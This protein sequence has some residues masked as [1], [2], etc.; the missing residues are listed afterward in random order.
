MNFS[1]NEAGLM[2]LFG[3]LLVVLLLFMTFT[4]SVL[5]DQSKSKKS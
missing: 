2:T 4:L 5:R 1:P 3:I